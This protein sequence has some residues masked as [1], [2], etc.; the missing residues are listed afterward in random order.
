MRRVPVSGTKS[1]ADEK[2]HLRPEAQ[3]RMQSL[4]PRISVS[5]ALLEIAED[6]DDGAVEIKGDGL[7][8]T[9]EL[10]ASEKGMPYHV[11]D[12]LDVTGGE[13]AQKLTR[14]GGSGN[15]KIVE[16]GSGSLF[17]P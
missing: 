14:S 17:A 3:E 13:L 7:P 10:G 12:L 4:D 6:L 16:I 2:P 1:H 8:S 15:R 9:D 11:L 5:G